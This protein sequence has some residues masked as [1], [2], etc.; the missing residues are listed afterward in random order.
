MGRK[1]PEPIRLQVIRAWLNGKSRDKIAQELG[2]STGAVSGI[3]E[4]LRKDDPQ[5][6]LLREVAVKLR[7]QNLDILSFAPIVRSYEVLREKGLLTDVQGSLDMMQ[8]RMEALI[9]AL[10]VFCFKE[11]LSIEDFAH[12]VTN[13]YNTADNLGIPIQRFP[14]YITELK[15]R[16]DTLTQ[17]RDRIGANKQA[18]LRDY[19]VTLELLREYNEN[20]PFLLQ[21][22]KYEQQSADAN[23]K[24]RECQR[25][26]EN[27][28]FWN[29]FEEQYTWSIPAYEL[30]KA[31]LGLGLSTINNFDGKPSLSGSDLKKWVMDV[32]YHPS[33]YVKVIREMRDI[34]NSHQQIVET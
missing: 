31:S 17:E 2:I 3:T 27:E 8:N 34:Y 7:N 18:A 32:F 16:I 25:E 13:M 26:L 9:I 10:E 19:G 24:R 6:D 30:N 29:E 1:I 11:R 22:Q 4:D 12:L 5:F 14:S 33:R 15:D 21:I 28:K 23:E 20:K